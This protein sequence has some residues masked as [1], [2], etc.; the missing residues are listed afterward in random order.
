[1]EASGMELSEPGGSA[2]EVKEGDR[3][4]IT[5]YIPPEAISATSTISQRIAEESVKDNPRQEK[6]LH[7]M[8]PPHFWGH[9]DAEQD[10]FLEENLASG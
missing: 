4:F 10:K 8:V 3:I 2:N 5:M 9:M 6:S 1:M 7:D